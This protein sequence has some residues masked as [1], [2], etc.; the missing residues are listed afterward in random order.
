MK[1]FFCKFRRI[2]DFTKKCENELF[3]R[4]KSK[5]H[6]QVTLKAEKPLIIN[7]QKYRPILNDIK[8]FNYQN[9]N[10]GKIIK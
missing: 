10:S 3:L 7:S 6:L 1:H 9:P 8:A 2:L 4:M 5:D